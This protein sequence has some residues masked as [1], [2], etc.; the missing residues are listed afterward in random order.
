[1]EEKKHQANRSQSKNNKQQEN[2]FNIKT[3]KI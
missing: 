2:N 1:M 3:N